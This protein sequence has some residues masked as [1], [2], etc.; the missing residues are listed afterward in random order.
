MGAE[1]E[2]VSPWA[3]SLVLGASIDVD[4]AGERRLEARRRR[5]TPRNAS[6]DDDRAKRVYTTWIV[7]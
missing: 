6:R 7:I 4:D 1:F 5:T 2:R 3:R